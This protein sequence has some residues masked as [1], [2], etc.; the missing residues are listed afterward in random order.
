MDYSFAAEELSESASRALGSIIYRYKSYPEMGYSTFT[1][2]YENCV[3]PVMDYASAIWGFKK[4]PKLDNIQHRAQRIFMGVHR[5]APLLGLEGYMGWL[6][7]TSQR[8]INMLRYWNRLLAMKN[9]RLTKQI[10]AWEYS[11]GRENWCSEL[12]EMFKDLNIEFLYENF[13]PCNIK[14]ATNQFIHLENIEWKK[15]IV[16]KP[17]LR[18]YR[19]LKSDK[20]TEKFVKINMTRH[21]RSQLA[22]LHFGILSIEIEVGRYRNKQ[23]E[24][25]KCS[26]CKDLVEDELHFMFDCGIY[27]DLRANILT[28][29]DDLDD[30]GDHR[31]QMLSEIYNVIQGKSRNILHKPTDAELYF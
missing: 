21:E 13:M 16:D 28:F 6:N 22:Q 9:S 23:I 17:K 12:L 20:G 3:I 24:D 7:R 18:L 30:L 1:K 29:N 27:N 19:M 10:F 8:R 5:F 26:F 11:N 14:L 2:L 25:R 15:A 31:E 4:F